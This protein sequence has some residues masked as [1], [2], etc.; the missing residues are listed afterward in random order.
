MTQCIQSIL[1][2]DL[3]KFTM[4]QAVLKLYSDAESK[5]ALKIRSNH[6]FT[7]KFIPAFE[8]ELEQMSELKLKDDEAR[9][10]KTMDFISPWYV[11]YLKSFRY[12][13]SDLS[14]KIV[15]GKLDLT[16][17][18]PWYSRILWEVPLMA[19]ISETYFNTEDTNWSMDGQDKRLEK[20][21]SKL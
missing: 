20:K 8:I 18:G 3:Y 4:Q 16:F 13:P 1:D 11:E 21:A 12:D 6:L 17:N 14:Y 9:F 2:N 19:A 15:D 10:L 5:Y 7:D